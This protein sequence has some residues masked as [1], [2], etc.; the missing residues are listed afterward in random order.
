MVGKQMVRGLKRKQFKVILTQD[1][2]DTI[3]R[4]DHVAA[5][6]PH[7]YIKSLNKVWEI[8][9]GFYDIRSTLIADDSSE[10]H[11]YNDQE[12]HVITKFYNC[13]SINDTN[14]LG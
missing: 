2:C 13:D 12:N 9:K 3:P 7:V 14:L 4:N 8:F 5:G 11:I 1:D 10:K 6:N